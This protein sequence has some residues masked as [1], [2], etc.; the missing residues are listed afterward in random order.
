MSNSQCL[1]CLVA[2]RSVSAR[3]VALVFVAYSGIVN[4]FYISVVYL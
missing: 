4:L 1:V 3:E 2:K